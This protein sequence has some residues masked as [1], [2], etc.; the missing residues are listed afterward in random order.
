MLGLLHFWAYTLIPNQ[1]GGSS[2]YD[3]AIANVFCIHPAALLLLWESEMYSWR[4]YAKKIGLSSQIA[5]FHH[6]WESWN[7]KQISFLLFG[8]WERNLELLALW[9]Q[10]ANIYKQRTKS[11]FDSLEHYSGTIC[12]FWK[13]IFNLVEVVNS[14]KSICKCRSNISI[15]GNKSSINILHHTKIMTIE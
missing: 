6:R 15:H 3:L 10:E 8:T 12:D 11:P 5:T 9:A 1:L 7:I 2:N 13:L 4:K 14:C